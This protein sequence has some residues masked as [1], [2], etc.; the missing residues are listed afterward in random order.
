[1]KALLTW[2]L[3]PTLH[4]SCVCQHNFL[5]ADTACI[6]H[7]RLHHANDVM[8]TTLSLLFRRITGQVLEPR[9]KKK[10]SA[11]LGFATTFGLRFWSRF[12]FR[13]PRFRIFWFAR[14]D[15][16]E[17]GNHLCGPVFEVNCSTESAASIQR[18]SG[19]F[20]RAPTDWS[21]TRSSA[22]L[23]CEQPWRGK[24]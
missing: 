10:K 23:W 22:W 24:C 2:S 11:R 1:M 13:T 19:A 12:R 18:Q 15:E 21:P 9:P 17:S 4:F 5:S 7:K 14:V 6:I 20:K 8:R 16:D 3:F